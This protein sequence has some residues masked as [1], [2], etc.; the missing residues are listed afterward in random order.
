MS[1]NNA[2]PDDSGNYTCV[3]YNI[4]AAS[5]LVH[6]LNE[7]NS[8][9]QLS[10]SAVSGQRGKQKELILFICFDLGFW[11]YSF[12]HVLHGGLCRKALRVLSYH[13]QSPFPRLKGF[14]KVHSLGGFEHAK[15]FEEQER[16]LSAFGQ[17]GGDYTCVPYNIHAASLLVLVLNEGNSA[18]QLSCFRSKR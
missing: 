12:L 7:G 5:V 14:Q 4:R 1:L 13:C 6:V 8:A 15:I 17:Q 10:N 18:A 3:P 16:S 9:A 11:R 2:G